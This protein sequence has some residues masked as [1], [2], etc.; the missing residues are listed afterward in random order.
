M[1]ASLLKTPGVHACGWEPRAVTHYTYGS[2]GI[3]F[4]TLLEVCRTCGERRETEW[5]GSRSID[6]F[7]TPPAAAVEDL[8]RK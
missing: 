4:T 5:H 2:R 7:K 3:P 1:R 6:D 8:I